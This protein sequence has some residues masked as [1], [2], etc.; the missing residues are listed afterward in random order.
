[1]GEG[2]EGIAAN[3]C[4]SEDQRLGSGEAHHVS[5]GPQE[6]LDITAGEMGEGEGSAEKRCL[7]G[8]ARNPHVVPNVTFP[9]K[10]TPG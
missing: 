7:R 6:D 10:S 5:S 4:D 3:S 8:L 9:L 2:S 1:M